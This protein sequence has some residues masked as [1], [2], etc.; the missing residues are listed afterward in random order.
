MRKMRCKFYVNEVAQT[1]GGAGQPPS[2]EVLKMSAVY[3]TAGD[4]TDWS[5]WT[6]S[7]SLQLHVTNPDAVGCF[8]PGDIV[9]IDIAPVDAEPSAP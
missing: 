7:G 1:A 9:Y 2:G 4:N 3:G 5:K 6:P 8:K